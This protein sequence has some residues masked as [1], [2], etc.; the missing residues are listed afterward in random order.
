VVGIV[1]GGDPWTQLRIQTADGRV[2]VD[3]RVLAGSEISVIVEQDQRT[4]G[5]DSAMANHSILPSSEQS[6][7]V[8]KGADG[9]IWSLQ[10]SGL[11]CVVELYDV[12]PYLACTPQG[13]LIPEDAISHSQSDGTEKAAQRAQILRQ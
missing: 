12:P 9:Q 6:E 10:L 2:I 7:A 5:A 13:L 8:P 1:S 11:R 3:D 4:Y